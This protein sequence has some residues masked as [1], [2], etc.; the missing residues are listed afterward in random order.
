MDAGGG[1]ATIGPRTITTKVKSQ[2]VSNNNKWHCTV[3]NL[4]H[5]NMGKQKCRNPTCNGVNPNHYH[6]VPKVTEQSSPSPSSSWF[7][8][9]AS[10]A[11]PPAPS[12]TMKSLPTEGVDKQVQDLIAEC[13]RKF[14]LKF[15]Q[16]DAKME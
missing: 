5:D 12:I 15:E 9:P 4:Q 16:E 11:Q 14:G 3:C 2:N 13:S 10:L 1:V 8:P 7:S 6:L